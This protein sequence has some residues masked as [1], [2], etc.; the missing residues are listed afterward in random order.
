MK[1]RLWFAAA[2]LVVFIAQCSAAELWL[3]P[4]LQDVRGD[5]AA[6]LWATRG[7]P[8]AGLVR[9]TVGQVTREVASVYA[10]HAPSETN[11]PET[12][13]LH[14]A[15]LT[16]LSAGTS[17][18]YKVF[19]D[20]VEVAADRSLQFRTPGGTQPIRFLVF[21]DTGDAGAGQ[22][23]VAHR[24]EQESGDFLL[25]VGD[26]AYYE[27]TFPQFQDTFFGIYDKLLSRLPFFAT[28]GNHDA[29]GGAAA[30]R[31]FFQ[32]NQDGVP[33][34][35]RGLYY[36]FD[37]G[38]IHFAVLDSN[39][40]LANAIAGTGAML[41]WLENDLRQ[42]QQTWRVVA[43]HHTPYPT[44]PYKLDDPICKLVLD[45]LTPI[46]ERH[47]VHLVLSGHEHIYQR[48]LAKQ[49]GFSATVPGTVYVTT[50]GGGSQYYDPGKAAFVAA[51]AA[52]PH[53]LRITVAASDMRVEAVTPD[54]RVLDDW[55][56]SAAPMLADLPVRDA[57]SFGGAVAPGGLVSLFGWNLAPAELR[58][59]HFPLA[60]EIGGVRLAIDGRPM[61]ILYAGRTQVNAL[62]PS[63][64][65]GPSTVD[66]RT[67]EGT[68]RAVLNV[69]ALAPAVFT[70]TANGV[71]TAAAIHVDGRLVTATAPAL[72]GEWI[73]V[74]ATGLGK[75]LGS[76]ADG[77]A[78]PLAPLFETATPV[79][80]TLGGTL[81]ESSAAVLAPGYVGLYQI[82][83]RIPVTSATGTLGLQLGSGGAT[84]VAVP[85]LVQ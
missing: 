84:S 32:P 15:D 20:G 14:R 24:L 30:Y 53:F 64:A 67:P 71:A 42:T 73:S 85:L 18:G 76:L 70:V 37:W 22:E 49:Q 31:T 4:Y 60:A 55:S 58:A 66:L 59:G 72:R 83:V 45:R 47:A 25:H 43:V 27:G 10:A 1:H 62:M 78:A 16:G 33:R 8:G 13:Y 38:N 50:G 40:S 29:P 46:L 48:T 61:P 51:S 9:F 52:G 11:L 75:V 57:A 23:L 34:D 82:N 39:D 36:S 81:V 63:A 19:V 21:G 80:A 2:F 54:G 3:G 12:L 26:I 77:A 5:R 6:V 41:N 28:P 65:L 79:R 44:T 69:A 56:I 74:F 17:Y 7:G 35:S 68:A